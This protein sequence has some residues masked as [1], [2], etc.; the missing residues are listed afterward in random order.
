[1]LIT[2]LTMDEMYFKR[3]FMIGASL[4]YVYRN[5]CCKSLLTPGVTAELENFWAINVMVENLDGHKNH[6]SFS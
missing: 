5:M 2:D 1:M 4:H 6:S 3:I